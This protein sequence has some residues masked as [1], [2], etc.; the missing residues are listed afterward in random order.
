MMTPID[1]MTTEQL[2]KECVL[3]PRLQI[4]QAIV[5]VICLAVGLL[6]WAIFN[7][8]SAL[9]LLFAA[10]CQLGI[11]AWRSRYIQKLELAHVN[12]VNP[13]S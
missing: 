8:W 12:R 5:G 3:Q 1:E 11:I 10:V 13:A 4:F 2:E 6:F 9:G 7:I